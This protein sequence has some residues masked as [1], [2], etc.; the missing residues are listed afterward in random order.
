MQVGIVAVGQSSVFFY[1]HKVEQV[2]IKES[3]KE[4][5]NMCIPFWEKA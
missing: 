1:L 2:T 4:V 3:C 5:V